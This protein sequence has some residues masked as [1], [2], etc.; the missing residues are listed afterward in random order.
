MNYQCWCCEPRHTT[1]RRA[2]IEE[3]MIMDRARPYWNSFT[4][5]PDPCKTS[6]THLMISAFPQSLSRRFPFLPLLLNILLFICPLPTPCHLF[7]H[8]TSPQHHSNREKRV[9][10]SKPPYTYQYIH[11]FIHR[12]TSNSFSLNTRKIVRYNLDSKRSY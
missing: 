12:H 5:C 4:L 10:K 3:V 8:D 1:L 6:F 7:S 2:H 11:L 9:V